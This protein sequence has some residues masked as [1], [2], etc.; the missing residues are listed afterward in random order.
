MRIQWIPLI[1]LIIINIIID[2]FIYRKLKKS[3][4][5]PKFFKYIHLGLYISLLAVIIAAMS[6]PNRSS[7]LSNGWLCAVMWMLFTYLAFY[8]PKYFA[9][10]F[11]PISLL[12]WLH[13]KSRHRVRLCSLLIGLLIF[14]AMWWGALV[15]PHTYDVNEVTAEFTNLPKEFDGYRIVQFSDLHS[16]SFNGDTAFVSR[17]I[18]KINALK[19]DAICFTGDLVN[20]M[21][22][23]AYP[24]KTIL[25][26]LH[27]PDGVFTILGNHDYDDYV[28]W[29]NDALKM[30]DRDSLRKFERSLGWKLLNDSTVILQ[31]GNG[32]IAMIGTE[33][34]GDP[35]FHTYGS[36]TH[37]YPNLNDTTFKILLQHNPFDWRAEIIKKTNID[38]MLAGH[39][40]AMQVMINVLGHHMSPARF[41]YR[42]WGG[43]YKEKNQMLYVNI[44]LGEVGMPMRLGATPEI[45][46]ITLKKKK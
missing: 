41:R 26:R 19:P 20:R 39:T 13:E 28:K 1:A 7:A 22:T 35:P 14:I 33:N 21:S 25:S 27:A 46:V 36:I 3:N 8:I 38:L 4:T 30:A 5:C 31:R 29:P 24:Y 37:T 32:K 44:G 16:G 11:Y 45:T 9:L 18:D 40:H 23:E 43:L 42:E 15:T 6:I 10:L 12:P 34:Y 17:C 2:F